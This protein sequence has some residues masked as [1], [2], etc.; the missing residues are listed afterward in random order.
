MGEAVELFMTPEAVDSARAYI[1]RLEDAVLSLDHVSP[2][3]FRRWVH[4]RKPTPS[5][6]VEFH[7]AFAEVHAKR[8]VQNRTEGR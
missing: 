5:S 4:P 8:C 6:M 3:D 1:R 2:G 7:E